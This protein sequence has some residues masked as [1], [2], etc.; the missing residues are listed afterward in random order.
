MNSKKLKKK[1]KKLLKKIGKRNRTFL[2][3]ACSK[4]KG[5]Y[6]IRV[7]DKS[8]YTPEITGNWNCG[9]CNNKGGVK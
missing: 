7:N 2:D 1:T 8:I 3:L 6:H 4:C 9:L 5:V